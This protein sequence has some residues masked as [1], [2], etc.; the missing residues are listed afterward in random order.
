MGKKISAQIAFEI[1]KKLKETE[2]KT[3]V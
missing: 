3:F 1:P 2:S